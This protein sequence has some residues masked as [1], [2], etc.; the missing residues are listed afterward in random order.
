[1]KIVFK[2]ANEEAAQDDNHDGR[3]RAKIFWCLK[4]V[5]TK[6]APPKKMNT[7]S[8]KTAAHLTSLK[9]KP[10]VNFLLNKE[11]FD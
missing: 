8:V 1:M 4:T 11:R 3:I 5:L 6:N 10:R 7:L 9:E 2:A